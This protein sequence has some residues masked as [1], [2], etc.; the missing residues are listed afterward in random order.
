MDK[1]KRYTPPSTDPWLPLQ[2]FTQA[3]IALGRT[4]SSLPTEQ[5]LHF[6]MAHAHA[7]DAVY[8]ELA[9]DKL[10]DDLKVFELVILQVK[11]MSANRAQYLQR[12]D[13][14]RLLHPTSAEILTPYGEH[15]ADISIIIADGLSASGINHHTAPL[16]NKLIPLLQAQGLV[17]GPICL[18]EQARVAL[19]DHIGHALQAKLTIILIGER[20]GLSAA[21]SVGSYLTYA[22]RPGLTDDA[23]NCVSNIRPGGLSYKMGAQKISYLVQQAF[24]RQLSGVGLKDEEG[25]IER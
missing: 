14:G 15:P 3:R 22:P 10:T 17:I 1:I 7:R 18:A 12:P 20:P 11:S 4:G 16:L 23:R 25:L 6:N 5:L 13:L 2:E 19:A 9:V 24:S 21:D 8:A